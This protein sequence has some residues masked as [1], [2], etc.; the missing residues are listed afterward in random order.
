MG[1]GKWAATAILECKPYAAGLGK[2][3]QVGG[4]V[5]L[6]AVGPGKRAS[7]GKYRQEGDDVKSHTQRVLDPMSVSN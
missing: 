5:R 6:L 4:H 3:T 2:F 7:L 1:L